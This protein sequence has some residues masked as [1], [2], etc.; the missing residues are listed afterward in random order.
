MYKVLGSLWLGR[1]KKLTNPVTELSFDV[2]VD[3]FVN[4]SEETDQSSHSLD[5]QVG[6]L[7]EIP[8]KKLTNPVTELSLDALIGFFLG[9]PVR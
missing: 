7:L 1:V 3:H 9:L 2:E 6:S 4:S 5:V 8:V